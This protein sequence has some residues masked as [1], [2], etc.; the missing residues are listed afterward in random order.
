M[1]RG[2]LT[3]RN[4]GAARLTWPAVTLVRKEEREVKER[5]T[6][7]DNVGCHYI[8]SHYRNKIL[9]IFYQKFNSTLKILYRKYFLK[10]EP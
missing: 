8:N 10:G 2:D 7:V 5:E 1:L 9:M 4:W 3:C 6:K